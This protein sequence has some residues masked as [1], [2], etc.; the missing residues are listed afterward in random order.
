MDDQ[1][2]EPNGK[3]IGSLLKG[4]EL[5]S[6]AIEQMKKDQI[7]MI[8]AITVQTQALDNVTEA[9]KESKK[10]LQDHGVRLWKLEKELEYSAREKSEHKSENKVSSESRIAWIAIAIAAIPAIS[11]VLVWLKKL[12]QIVTEP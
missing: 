7:D 1:P 5:M 6:I 10:E 8:K 4:Y 12:I 2:R 9:G 3:T 11:T